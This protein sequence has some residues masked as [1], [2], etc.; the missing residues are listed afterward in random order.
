ML[1][2]LK[3]LMQTYAQETASACYGHVV[4]ALLGEEPH[5]TLCVATNHAKHYDLHSEN[6]PSN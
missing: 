4:A 2:V 5:V 1:Q 6:E 3:V